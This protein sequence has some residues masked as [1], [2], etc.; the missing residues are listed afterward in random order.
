MLEQLR[1]GTKNPILLLA[2]GILIVVFV[3]YFGPGT[4]MLSPSTR[5][6][7]AT[8]DGTD[9]YTTDVQV[10]VNRVAQ[11]E[12]KNDP[13]KYTELQRQATEKLALLHLLELKSR[14]HGFTVTPDELREFLMDSS[15][16]IDFNIYSKD[17]KFDPEIYQRF[18]VNYLGLSLEG[19]EELKSKELLARK[20][21]TLLSSTLTPLPAEI[22]RLNTLRNTKVNL[23][24]IAFDPAK[25]REA[26]E[27]TDA[28]V[29]AFAEANTEAIAKAYAADKDKYTTPKQVRIRRLMIKKVPESGSDADKKAAETRW[30]DAQKRV[31]EGKEDFAAVV[32]ELSEDI[33]YKDKGG[34]MGWSTKDSTDEQTWAIIDAMKPGEVKVN[35]GKKFAWFLL[36]LEEI[37][38]ARTKPLEEV[39][40][41]IARALIFDKQGQAMIDEVRKAILDRAKA[42]PKTSLEDVLKAVRPKTEDDAA[43]KD[44]DAAKKDDAKK[45]DAAAKK[46]DA[47]PEGDDAKKDDVN[48]VWAA[49]S[50]R[51]TGDFAQSPGRSMR[52]DL[53]TKGFVPT[54]TPW[55]KIPTIGDSP[56]LAKAAFAMTADKPVMEEPFTLKDIVYI[57]RLK[58]RKTPTKEDLAKTYPGIE[59]ELQTAMSN[60]F[61][62]PWQAIVYSPSAE[63]DKVSPW[64]AEMLKEAT[65]NGQV[66]IRKDV[67]KTPEP[68]AGG[69]AG[70]AG[71][72]APPKQ[73]PRRLP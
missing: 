63:L 70:G 17:G 23:E 6:V 46:D 12:L 32:K 55:T 60:A 2:F 62:G 38:P 35:D 64:L 19:Y 72:A 41:E 45:D 66:R 25:L 18:I 44:E 31:N 67:F 59:A 54:F 61:L 27:F 16:N 58:E 42:E 7:A 49:V 71:G 50:V 65:S 33:V 37:K 56:E 10:L 1:Q 28:Q 13:V 9:L 4:E 47:K 73:A 14:Q 8:V 48:P 57:V 52:Y 20:Y 22:E 3:L 43:K 68:A 30:K 11:R 21:L 34:D 29:K 36:K 24:Y 40:D 51:A 53:N 39:R 15:R 5:A 69:A 26:I